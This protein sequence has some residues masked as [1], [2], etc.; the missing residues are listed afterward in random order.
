MAGA[1]RTDRDVPRE[2]VFCA[3][4]GSSTSKNSQFRIAMITCRLATLF[5]ELP[6]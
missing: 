3:A 6:P 5:S 2:A 1:A 4:S